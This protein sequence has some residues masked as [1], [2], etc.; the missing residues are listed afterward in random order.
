LLFIIFTFIPLPLP[1]FQDPLSGLY[2]I[3]W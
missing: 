3:I 2:G 1:L